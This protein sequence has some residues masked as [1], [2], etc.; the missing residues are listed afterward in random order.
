MKSSFK[1]HLHSYI[2]S[3]K[4]AMVRLST[5]HKL[6]EERGHKQSYAER[7]LRPSESPEVI[8]MYNAKGHVAGYVW[9]GDLTVYKK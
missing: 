2:R 8:T 3:K 4:G 5:I 9:A 6:A 1:N 7:Q